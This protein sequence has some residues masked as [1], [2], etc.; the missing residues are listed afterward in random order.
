M[1]LIPP[2]KDAPSQGKE[3]SL[4]GGGV[5]LRSP[6]NIPSPSILSVATTLVHATITF[7]FSVGSLQPHGSQQGIFENLSDHVI[8][9]LKTFQ[10][11]PITLGTKSKLVPLA[12]RS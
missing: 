11:L 10:G 4:G 6:K 9:L 12:S 2:T 1:G 8:P 7:A 5:Y 3:S